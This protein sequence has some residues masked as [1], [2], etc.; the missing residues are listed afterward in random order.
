MNIVV[1]NASTR[2]SNDALN[3]A[4]RAVAH[5]ARYHVAPVWNGKAVAITHAKDTSLVPA[6][7]YVITVYDDADQA[8]ALGY[9]TED[10]DGTVHGK[11]FVSPVLDNGGTA[12]T[13]ALSVSAVLSHEVLETIVDPH[14]QLWASDGADGLYAYEACDA[15][16]DGSYNVTVYHG[17]QSG[18]VE[19]AVSNFVYPAYFDAQ[20][21]A[22]TKLDQLGQ[23]TK[24]FEISK[25]GYAVKITLG[26][27]TK[28]NQVFGEEFPE[29]KKAAKHHDLARL[30]RRVT[31][32]Q[33]GE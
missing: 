24:P 32:L 3:L 33:V 14:V 1:I 15:V 20:A 8:D 18:Y 31:H 28:V 23:L 7:S 16:E 25:G 29:F 6:E 10:T 12:L 19:V 13:G 27:D 22:D 4:V 26:R 21:P 30:Q 9:H 17:E 2:L 5:Q 11:V